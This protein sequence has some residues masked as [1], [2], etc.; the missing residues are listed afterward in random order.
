MAPVYWLLAILFLVSSAVFWV[1]PYPSQLA[2][3]SL[4]ASTV[5]GS[6]YLAY[7]F[8]QLRAGTIYWLGYLLYVVLQVNLCIAPRPSLLATASMI[9]ATIL[10][11]LWIIDFIVRNRAD[12]WRFIG[13]LRRD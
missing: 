6:A 1:A 3:A 8:A 11:F 4:V 5:L 7:L 13:S 2:T 12:V 9:G 10:V